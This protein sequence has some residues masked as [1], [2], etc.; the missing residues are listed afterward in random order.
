MMW[1]YKLSAR[2]VRSGKRAGR[3]GVGYNTHHL[4]DGFR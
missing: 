3:P 2:F 1:Q 4:L